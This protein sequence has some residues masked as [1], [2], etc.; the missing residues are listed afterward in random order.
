M[1][2]PNTKRILPNV[3]LFI[4]EKNENLFINKFG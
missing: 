3:A 4:C 2:D 1:L